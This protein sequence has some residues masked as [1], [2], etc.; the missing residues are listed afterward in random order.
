[1]IAFQPRSME[2]KDKV[3]SDKNRTCS[4]VDFEAFQKMP[5]NNLSN[6][7][8]HWDP[9][10]FRKIAQLIDPPKS[11]IETPPPESPNHNIHSTLSEER[12]LESE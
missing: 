3:V 2:E 6:R 5:L 10:V 11:P 8:A 1:M 9:K 4:L 7:S 12:K